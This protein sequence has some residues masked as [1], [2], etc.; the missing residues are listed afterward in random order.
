MGNDDTMIN[1][2]ASLFDST[3]DDTTVVCDL[4]R[5]ST[6]ITVALHNFACVIPVNT[7]DEAF[8]IKDSLDSVTLAGEDDL[9]NIP[10][11]DLSNSPTGILKIKDKDV[12]VLKTSN[13]TKVLEGIKQRDPDIK[14]LVGTSINA[15]SVAAKALELC[16]HEIEL[17]MAGRRHIFNIEDAIGVGLIMEEIKKQ[18]KDQN[19]SIHME[20]SAK[21]VYLLAEDH[22]RAVDLIRHSDASVRLNKRDFHD[23]LILASRINICSNVGIYDNKEI[24]NINNKWEE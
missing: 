12:L 3:T 4:L 18:A 5:A 17:I 8:E 1:I 6:T 19:I 21:A 14:V 7:A 9:N 2:K 22:K 24:Y 23:D 20:E 11:F 16:D 10:G 15:K 13:G